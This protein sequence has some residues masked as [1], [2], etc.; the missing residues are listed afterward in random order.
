MIDRKLVESIVFEVIRALEKEQAPKTVSNQRKLLII[1]DASRTSEKTLEKL[2]SE[3][4]ISYSSK[5][6][7]EECDSADHFVFFH[8]SQDL[9]V[10]GALG[11]SDTPETV[12]LSHCLLAGKNVTISPDESLARHLK[13]SAGQV[14]GYAKQLFKYKEQLIGYGV[15]V[16]SIEDFALGSRNGSKPA[17]ASAGDGLAGISSDGSLYSWLQG[18]Q[19]G[20]PNAAAVKREKK[21]LLTQRDVQDAKSAEIIVCKSTIITPSARDAAKELGKSIIVTE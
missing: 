21:K 7:A 15:K 12:L 4:E 17:A 5:P 10:K 14:S 1:G 9:M 3:W 19:D 11:I 8:A 16:E 6:G 20:S 18:T 2:K 13:Q